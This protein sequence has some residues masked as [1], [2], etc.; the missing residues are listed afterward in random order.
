MK[1][2][3]NFLNM[4]LNKIIKLIK[5]KSKKD[6]CIIK[7]TEIDQLR[8]SLNVYYINVIYFLFLRKK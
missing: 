1:I 3:I 7:E 2:K 6:R 8:L 5:F 4:I